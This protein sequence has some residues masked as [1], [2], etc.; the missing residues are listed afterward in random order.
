M[1]FCVLRCRQISRTQKSWLCCGAKVCAVACRVI[2]APV[3]LGPINMAAVV[4][5]IVQ[6]F[7]VR[8]KSRKKEIKRLVFT[9]ISQT[10]T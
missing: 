4:A 5:E 6:L 10:K 3:P 2:S 9:K 8:D 1:Y 7:F